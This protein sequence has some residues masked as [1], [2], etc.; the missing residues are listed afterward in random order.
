MIKNLDKN[1]IA[2]TGFILATDFNRRG[3]V[4]EIALETED[5]LQYIISLNQKGKELFDLLYSKLTVYGSITGEDVHGNPILKV[6]DY[7]VLD[8]IEFVQ[9]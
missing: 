2:I 8:R 6:E 7:D 4:Q 3:K 1:K 9:D 5:F